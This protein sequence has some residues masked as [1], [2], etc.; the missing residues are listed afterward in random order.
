M[1]EVAERYRRSMID[2][3]AQFPAAYAALS[4]KEWKTFRKRLE[5]ERPAPSPPAGSGQSGFGP[6]EN[7]GEAPL[8]E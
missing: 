6:G 1:G 3:R 8:G 2:L 4:G 7:V 5:R